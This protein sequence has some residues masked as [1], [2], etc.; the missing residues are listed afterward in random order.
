MTT[1]IK[2]TAKIDTVIFD[3]DGT[4]VHTAPDLLCATNHVL[5]QYGRQPMVLDDILETVSFGAKQMIRRGFELTGDP[6]DEQQLDVMFMRFID[7]YI[8]NI[9]VDSRPFDGCLDLL[10][11]CQAKGMKL[12]VCTNKHETL[13]VKLLAELDMLK[14]FSAIIGPDTINIAKPDP[15]P[16]RETVS[17]IGGN[18][19]KSI[20]VGDS[21]I[22][23]L[24]AKAANVPVIALTF[25]Y[26]DEPIEKLGADYVLGHYDEMGEILLP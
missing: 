16:Y 14:Y 10:E 18:I 15:A 25:G 8:A 3:L 20:M 2:T 13:A 19:H 6:A 7:F 12:G 5:A 23:I 17:R 11:K 1:D 22:D 26:S 24:T 21:K 9:A 4:L